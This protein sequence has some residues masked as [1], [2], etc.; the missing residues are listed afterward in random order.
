[1][2]DTVTGMTNGAGSDVRD[3][4]DAALEFGAVPQ[5]LLHLGEDRSG[6]TA[7][8]ATDGLSAVLANAGWPTRLG[9]TAMT[10]TS[11]EQN[12]GT[13][14]AGADVEAR[15]DTS[16]SEVGA[17]VE[18]DAEGAEGTGAEDAENTERSPVEE[19]AT[20]RAARFERDALQ[21]LDQLYSAAL[22]MTRN[23]AD[24][25]DLVQETFAKAFAA[26]HQYRPGTNLKA[27][28]YRILT[29]TFIN[30]YR[31]KQREPQQSQTEDV[32]DWQIARAASHTSRGL[33]SAEAEAL[34]RLPDSDVKRALAE[35]PEDRR[36]VVYYADVEGFP[37]KEIAEI[38]GTPI[39]TV[40]SRLHRGRRQ[41]REL[42]ADYA[43]QRGLVSQ[44]PGGA[45]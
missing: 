7:K 38:M 40:M 20:A 26:F 19:D 1:M 16:A 30:S 32:E 44:A 39:G 3:V 9:S 27:W 18:T 14:E 37:Y 25:E 10:D 12:E 5:H 17:A 29:N 45:Q 31:K 34:D 11:R 15:P 21:Y 43:A 2:I 24:A 33:R 36:M 28:L 41:L 13:G 35:L 8:D 23:P 4:R 6:A 42:L 22:R